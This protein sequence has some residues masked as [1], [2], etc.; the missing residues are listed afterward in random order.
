M[1][2]KKITALVLTAALSVSVF[3]GCNNIDKNA[4]VGSTSDYDI[5][6]GITNFYAHYNQ[7]LY[8]DFYK[9]VLGSDDV[10]NSDPYGSG[11][12]L[13]D[14]MREQ[15]ME[16]LHEMYTLKNNM[17]KYQVS[18]SEDEEKAIEEAVEKF[19]DANSKKAID[20]MGATKKT[21]TEM[22]ELFTIRAKLQEKI[23]AEADV[24]VTDEEANMRGYSQ[25]VIRTDS[26]VDAEGNS[27]AYTDEEKSKLKDKAAVVTAALMTDGATLESVAKANELEVTSSTYSTYD[28]ADETS[29]AVIEAL[30]KLK[31]GETSECIE[32]S[33]GYYFV[34][35]INDTDKDATEKN[36]ES[37]ITAR[38]TAHYNEV[39]S[40]WQEEDEWS[41]DT[42]TLSKVV[43][44]Y[45]LTTTNPDKV[46]STEK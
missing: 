44:D 39:L 25:I 23:Y 19:M 28:N 42:A 9:S 32:T 27:V 11:S 1:K 13:G 46:E 4:V 24:N 12:T 3:T 26:Y 14:M 16:E 21:V 31:V 41:V 20:V 35:P 33:T 40:G 43:F 15:I 45:P 7:S 22:L 6:L 30:K 38:K 5:T 2:A 34:S 10:W 8:E 29:D 18:I 36:K 17:D 37:L